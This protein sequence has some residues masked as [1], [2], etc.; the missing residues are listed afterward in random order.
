MTSRFQPLDQGLF[1]KLK[2]DYRKILL[3]DY[4]KG[5]TERYKEI[6]LLPLNQLTPTL[7]AEML[8]ELRKATDFQIRTK[9]AMDFL[10]EAW[11]LT[12]KAGVRRAWARANILSDQH[13]VEMEQ[14]DNENAEEN[15]EDLQYTESSNNL[16][17]AFN[18]FFSTFSTLYS[19]LDFD[20]EFAR[21]NNFEQSFSEEPN[22]NQEQIID[23]ALLDNSGSV[24]ITQYENS[25]VAE[26]AESENEE[27]IET[28]TR[29]DI[30]IGLN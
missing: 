6:L 27:V 16:V 23:D 30:D 1:N 18:R 5:I 20:F 26:G 28:L 21:I 15:K 14:I 2:C 4:S 19:N 3:Q 9:K 11:K 25:L 8:T 22:L 12:T 29:Q 24:A 13:K 7:K 10:A 17:L